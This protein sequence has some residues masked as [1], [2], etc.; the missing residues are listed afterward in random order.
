[1]PQ[2]KFFHLSQTKARLVLLLATLLS[3]ASAPAV[4]QNASKD[5]TLIKQL[6]QMDLSADRVNIPQGWTLFSDPTHE[7]SVVM[8]EPVKASKTDTGGA[9][10]DGDVG[11]IT[12]RVSF[13]K[14]STRPQDKEVI[15]FSDT[16]AEKFVEL[17]RTAGHPIDMKLVREV[18][19]KNWAG[20]IYRYTHQS[21]QPGAV[22]I[23]VEN[24]HVLVLHALGGADTDEATKLFFSSLVVHDAP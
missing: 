11:K 22:Q 2:S 10:Y 6:P 3:L 12:Y 20:R 1:M 17:M 23:A 16:F 24:R 21:G 9:V 14:R 4:A 13:R 8:P 5:L 19:G 18:S 15:G 7:M